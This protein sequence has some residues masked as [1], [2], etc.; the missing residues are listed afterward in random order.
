MVQEN[1]N[2]QSVVQVRTAKLEAVKLIGLQG[3]NLDDQH[4]LFAQMGERAN[5]LPRKEWKSV[6]SNIACTMPLSG[7][8]KPPAKPV[9][10][11]GWAWPW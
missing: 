3:D 6:F 5:E 9:V 1:V 4:R 8:W 10:R 11:T 7:C 2:I